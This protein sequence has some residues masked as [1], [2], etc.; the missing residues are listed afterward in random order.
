M[1]THWYLD[2]Y[3]DI[4]SDGRSEASSDS[5]SFNGQLV[6]AGGPTIFPGGESQLLSCLR[7]PSKSYS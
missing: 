1:E 6:I 4:S 2:D 5:I 3:V 7:M